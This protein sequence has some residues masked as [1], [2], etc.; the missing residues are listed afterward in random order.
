MKIIHSFLIWQ[1]IIISMLLISGIFLSYV[2]TE[3]IKND[4][5]KRTEVIYSNLILEH[6]YDEIS[7]DDFKPRHTKTAK[8]IFESFFQTHQNPEIIGIKVWAN[9]STILFSN[10]KEII[11]SKISGNQR[12]QSA[13]NGEIITMIRNY[14][15]EEKLTTRNVDKVMAIYVPIYDKDDVLGVVEIYVDPVFLNNSITKS[16]NSVFSIIG[17]II[18]MMIVVVIINFYNNKKQIIEPIKKLEKLIDEVAKG[19]YNFEIKEEGYDEIKNLSTLFVHMKD[20]I[21]NNLE[22]EEIIAI[23]K[24]KVKDARYVAIGELSARMA[25][26]IRNPLSVISTTVDNIKIKY[27]KDSKDVEEFDRLD[28]SINRIVHQIQGVLEFVKE[29]PIEPRMT[30]FSEIIHESFDSIIIPNNVK[31]IFPKNDVMMFCDKRLFSIV[32]NNLIINAVQAIDASGTIKI[33]IEKNDDEIIIQVTDSGKE[34]P[35]DVINKI[36]VPLFTTKQTG[37]GLGLASVKTIIESHNG[38]ISVT[39]PPTIF[40]ITLPKIHSQ[41]T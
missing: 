28:R 13:M 31:M 16:S 22:L 3:N 7:P 24:Q 20:A 21:K 41:S 40:T 23:E 14:D 8:I 25:H 18:L 1:L 12:Y 11:G 32:M 4:S 26:D 35:K 6:I 29:Q 39:S 2:I 5:I 30:K 27:A 38:T 36:F 9:D 19:N 33:T 10:N 17:I 37:T 34:I 15:I